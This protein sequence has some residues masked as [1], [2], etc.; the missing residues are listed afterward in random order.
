MLNTAVPVQTTLS[1]T[2]RPI[3]V[4]LVTV[5][6]GVPLYTLSA[7]TTVGVTVAAVIAAVVVA[8]V[9]ASV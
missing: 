9:L 7:T 8:V 1:S 4:Q 2:T 3:N 6:L 5:A